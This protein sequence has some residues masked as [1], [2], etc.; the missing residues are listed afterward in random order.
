MKTFLQSLASLLLSWGPWGIL[1][2]AIIDSAGIPIPGGVDALVVLIASQSARSGYISAALAAVGSTAGSFVLYYLARKGGEA[3]LHD[4]TQH[5]W[6]KRFRHWF[7]HYGLLTVFIPALLPIPL[8]MKIPVLCAGA[9][10][11]R[12]R[13]FLLVVFAARIPRYFGLAYLGAE[14]GNYPL[15]YLR[16]HIWLLLGAAIGLFLFL[17]TLIKIKDVVRA[18][19]LRARYHAGHKD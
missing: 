19:E 10:G 15:L 16:S 11:V 3:Y 12:R 8:P 14:M 13:S 18:R 1:L 6:G 2:L 4:K 5:G 17:L 7:L 9:L